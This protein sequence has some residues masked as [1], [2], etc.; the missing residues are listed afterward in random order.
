MRGMF[1]RP[2]LA[3]RP[4]KQIA[5]DISRRDAEL[6]GEGDE[7]VREVL[8]HAAARGQRFVDRRI[9]ARA[10]GTVF[11][12]GVHLPHEPPQQLQ[13]DP[14]CLSSPKLP[15]ELVE[16]RRRPGERAGREMLEPLAGGGQRV[17]LVPGVRSRGASGIG[18]RSIESTS[19]SAVTTRREWRVGMSK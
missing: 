9:D 4:G 2:D 14:R 16:C 15:R 3:L 12:Q 11:E 18:S 6:P 17:D 19:A 8:A 5:A 13:R 1:R 7:D 10:L